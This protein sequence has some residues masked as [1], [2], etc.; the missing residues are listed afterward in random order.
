MEISDLYN[1]FTEGT[2]NGEHGSTAQYWMIYIKLV[3]LF[4][5]FNRSC[6]TNDLDL[7]IHSLRNICP[8]F[9]SCHRPNYAR[10]MVRY[11]HNL[12]NMDITHPGVRE[13]LSNGA[14]SI[15]RSS[16]GFSRNAVDI[17]LEQTVN[18]DAASHATGITAFTNSE[19]ARKKW[20]LTMSPRSSIVGHL[21]VKA[22]LKTHE[23]VSKL[24]R[25]HR[26][27]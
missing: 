15:R 14:L 17:T 18:A 25:E 4:L 23:D 11:L 5:Q 20:M 3:E 26:I 13:A 10:W 22:G 8:I 24:L 12:L 6:R 19:Q 27:T 2:L 7:F 1:K 16:K 9:F 21:L